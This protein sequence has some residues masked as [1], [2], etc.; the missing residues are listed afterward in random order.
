MPAGEHITIPTGLLD[1]REIHG[2]VGARSAILPEIL[3]GEQYVAGNGLRTIT[4][5]L[6]QAVGAAAGVVV[7]FVGAP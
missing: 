3:D 5:Q 7:A 6:C 1:A 2:P 4:S